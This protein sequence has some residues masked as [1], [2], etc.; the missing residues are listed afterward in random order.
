AIAIENRF[1]LETLL[2]MRD[3]HTGLHLVPALPRLV[4]NAWSHLRKHEAYRTY[5]YS[6]R[7]YAALVRS[8]GFRNTRVLDLAP[9]YN[10]Y[11]FIMDPRDRASY[12]LLWR[13]RWTRAFA[14]GTGAVRRWLARARPSWLGH[15]GYAYLVIGGETDVVLDATH[16]L[17]NTVRELGLEPGNSRFAASLT[18]PGTIAILTHDGRRPTG[19]VTLSPEALPNGPLPTLR[20]RSLAEYLKGRLEPLGGRPFGDWYADV[21][22]VTE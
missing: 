19:L 1:A 17:W 10:D 4:A 9:S 12:A 3:T 13:S 11:D 2:G 15:L 7:G 18:G 14:P 6:R 5:L 8:A 21:Y 16:P 20:A 22:R